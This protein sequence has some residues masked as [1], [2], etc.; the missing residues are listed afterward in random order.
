M[1]EVKSDDWY[2][3]MVN[4]LGRLRDGIILSTDTM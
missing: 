2:P 4:S 3:H 1:T